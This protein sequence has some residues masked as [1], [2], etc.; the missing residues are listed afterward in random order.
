MKNLYKA[1]LAVAI[2]A[3]AFSTQ[4]QAQSVVLNGLGSSAMFLE[5]GLAASSTTVGTI[6]ANCVWSENTNTAEASDTAASTADKGSAWVA[7][8]EGGGTC[9]A[10]GSTSSIYA[11]LQTD[12]V[13]GNRCIFDSTCTMNYSAASG[14]APAGLILTGGVAN[15]GTTGEC[16]LPATIASKLA[17]KPNFA[18][19]DIRPEDAAFAIA[20]AQGTCGTAIGS[21]SYLEL[22]Y[23]SG[24]VI[25][26]STEGL[27]SS[28]NVV[29]FGLS[30]NYTV[31][32][33]GAVPVLVVVASSD[34]TGNA[35]TQFSNLS[36]ADLAKLLDGTYSTASAAGGTGT[37]NIYTFERE[38]LSGTYNTME[39]NVPN[40]ITNSAYS[41][42]GNYTSQDV[43][44][45]QL[46]SQ[47]DC[48]STTFIKITNTGITWTG[49]ANP[50]VIPSNANGS[51]RFRSIGT[52]NELKSVRLFNDTTTSALTNNLGY[53][54][55]SVAN[56]AG[57]A[58]PLKN[59]AGNAVTAKYLEVDGIDPLNKIR[60]TYTGTIPTAGTTA[61]ADVD[62][63][64]V[65]NGTY[66]IYSMLRLVANTPTSGTTTAINALTGAVQD[67]VS[68]GTTT[69]RPD[70]APLADM[71]VVRSHFIPPAGTGLP[72][73]ANNGGSCGTEAGGDVGGVVLASGSCVTN[74]RR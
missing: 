23:T 13:V 35:I 26:G 68:F 73:T 45:D 32:P 43:G 46:A 16:D 37:D 20:R 44:Q 10:P 14:T 4:M 55:W 33:L 7:W 34:T 54:F 63:H 50:M 1:L 5:L 71:T 52:G 60:V 17:V 65:E 25:D 8:T 51:T 42:T 62:L 72:T 27:S 70:F 39:Y 57:F 61:L 28:F 12:S 9:A 66:P 6:H 74:E 40:T 49:S 58:A 67:F 36:S 69:S 53:G 21:T 19:S 38:P 24:S 15:C 29:N 48:S 22:G 2:V 59:N 30:S 11:Y 31:T 3:M 64:T 41:I 56:F 47:K 18:G